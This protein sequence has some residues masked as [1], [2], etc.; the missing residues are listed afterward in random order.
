MHIV[1]EDAP[2]VAEVVERVN[3]LYGLQLDPFN[4]K[5]VFRDQFITGKAF[6][7]KVS[8]VS[9][10]FKFLTG[11]DLILVVV[12]AFWDHLSEKQREALVFHE[13]LH[14]K[15]KFNSEG[16]KVI[17]LRNHDLEE[18]SQVVELY[19]LWNNELEKF[20]K[21]IRSA[22]YS[23]DSSENPKEEIVV[24]S[25]YQPK[26]KGD[27]SNPPQGGTA[28]KTIRKKERKL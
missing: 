20:S 26:D 2:E 18:F 27:K 3:K 9:P 28:A 11:I 19:G 6:W 21:S 1:Y 4:I 7:A 17:S 15:V 23:K 8:K 22:G 10:L 16:K 13:L 5:C 12:R 24:M 14:C 25:G